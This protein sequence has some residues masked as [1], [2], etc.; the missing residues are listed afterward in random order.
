MYAAV[1]NVDILALVSPGFARYVAFARGFTP[2]SLIAGN[3]E[4]HAAAE[5]RTDLPP[6]DGSKTPI[7]S[8]SA[9]IAGYDAITLS[10]SIKPSASSTWLVVDT[11]RMRKRIG[12]A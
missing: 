7:G 4:L 6:T 5:P 10:T 1:M 3:G 11:R 2:F 12:P 8:R 9:L